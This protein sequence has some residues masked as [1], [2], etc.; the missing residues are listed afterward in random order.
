[1]IRKTDHDTDRPVPTV[2][3]RRARRALLALAV[4]A[5]LALPAAAVSFLRPAPAGEP[6][7]AIAWAEQRLDLS[8][9]QK[10]RIR[11]I[12]ADHRE[13]LVA[14]LK[15]VEE[16]RRDLFEAIHS[17]PF[18][19]PQ[20]R[21]ASAAVAT[22][23]EELAVTRAEIGDEIYDVLTPEQ[24]AEAEQIREDVEALIATLVER[25]RSALLSHLDV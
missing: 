18:S 11:A 8:D 15:S 5:S 21:Q 13:E 24:Q 7:L 23:A 9:M 6:P 1:M 14:E 19:E 2:R 25:L 22:V 20:V 17:H 10:A 4:L 12:L 3:R 16:A